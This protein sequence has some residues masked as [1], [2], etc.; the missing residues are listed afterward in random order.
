MT[1]T[2]QAKQTW[3]PVEAQLKTLALVPTETE[4]IT[5]PFVQQGILWEVEIDT[6]SVVLTDTI[7]LSLM[8]LPS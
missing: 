7:T 2:K 6:V 4:T 1:Q 3:F 8:F 5:A